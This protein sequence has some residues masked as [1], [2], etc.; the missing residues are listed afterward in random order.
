MK[1]TLMAL[2]VVAAIVIGVLFTLWTYSYIH[3]AATLGVFVTELIFQGS[4]YG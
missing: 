1:L 2:I 4:Y 3:A